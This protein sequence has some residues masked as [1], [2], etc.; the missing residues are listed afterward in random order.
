MEKK[1][2]IY[3]LLV[4]VVIAI[5]V[6]DFNNSFKSVENFSFSPETVY[7]IKTDDGLFLKWDSG[8]KV[9]ASG[10]SST[11]SAYKFNLEPEI[12]GN[13]APTGYYWLKNN[14]KYII[15]EA[16]NYNL[17]ENTDKFEKDR[18][19]YFPMKVSVINETDNSVKITFRKSVG[20]VINRNGSVR[21]DNYNFYMRLNNKTIDWNSSINNG[22]TLTLIP[23]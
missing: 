12:D 16:D 15:L 1:L 9:S 22:L 17:K 14:N 13:G 20:V 23:V 4:V 18:Q 19:Q 5:F 6:G 10:A 2:I 7:K 3:L 21:W 11:S 8:L